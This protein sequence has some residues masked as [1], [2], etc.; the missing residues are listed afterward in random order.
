MKER[1]SHV[2][3]IALRIRRCDSEHWILIAVESLAERLRAKVDARV[4]ALPRPLPDIGH[5]LAVRVREMIG[6]IANVIR[7]RKHDRKGRGQ[8]RL[9]SGR[10]LVAVPI[11]T[12]VD[13]G[14]HPARP[15]ALGL[16]Y[17]E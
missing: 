7:V 9:A 13:A 17:A 14:P 10:P 5:E 1:D 4:G 15:T 3:R 2:N 11:V 16:C 8:V 12:D 6:Q